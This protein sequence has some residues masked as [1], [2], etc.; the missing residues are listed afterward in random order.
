MIQNF[1]AKQILCINRKKEH[2]PP[3]SQLDNYVKHFAI[4]CKGALTSWET[5][6]TLPNPI[7]IRGMNGVVQY[8]WDNKR[9]F[10]YMDNGYFE[11]G[12][13][14][15]YARVIQNH[16]HDIQPIIPRPRDRLD[17][18]THIKLLPFRPGRR[19]LIAPPSPKSLGVWNIQQD[20]WVQEIITEI[21]KYTDRPIYVRVK[22]S[23]K[24]RFT[25]D[26][27]EEDLANDVH[28][29]VTYNSVAA[30]DALISGRP[31]FTLGPNAAGALC[32]KDLSLIES[33]YIPT[34]DEREAWL[35]HLS[36]SQFTFKEMI[37]GVAWRILNPK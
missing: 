23:R 22:R 10:Y 29:L 13:K 1:P 20:Q 6:K 25:N 15:T 26:T 34:T 8:C 27:I 17:K 7:C 30:V 24:E 18:L 28:C 16:I 14:K 9:K 5:A 19:I 35:R 3:K 4:G 21:K 2:L 36:Y 12:D 11:N 37:D 32:L 31:A 33:P